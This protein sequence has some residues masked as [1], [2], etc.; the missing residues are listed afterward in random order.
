MLLKYVVHTR[1]SVVSSALNVKRNKIKSSRSV[2]TVEEVFT[3]SFCDE[4]VDSFTCVVAESDQA[5]VDA[6]HVTE[7]RFVQ[8][9]RS[10]EIL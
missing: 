9:R 1:D 5:C 3:K 8:V 4:T 7:A 2:G 6:G 10:E